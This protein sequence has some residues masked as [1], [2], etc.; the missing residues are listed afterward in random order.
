[1]EDY[2]WIKIGEVIHAL[3][4]DRKTLWSWDKKG[5]LQCQKDWRGIRFYRSD[6]VEKLKKSMSPNGIS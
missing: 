3:G 1:M 6:Q 5:K 2:T 4:V